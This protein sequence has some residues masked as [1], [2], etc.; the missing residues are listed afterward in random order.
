MPFYFEVK[1]GVLLCETH[2]LLLVLA[3]KKKNV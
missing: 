3:G 2:M 1:N